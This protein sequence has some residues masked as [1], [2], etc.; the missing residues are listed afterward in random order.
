[1]SLSTN[2][3]ALAVRLATEVN[4][5]RAEIAVAGASEFVVVTQAD[6]DA[7][8]PPDANTLYVIVG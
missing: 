7:L 4:A 8:S 1:M 5:L 2:V 6:Y 3:D